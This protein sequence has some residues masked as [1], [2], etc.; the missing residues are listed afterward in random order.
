MRLPIKPERAP[1]VTRRGLLIGGGVGL[2]LLVGWSVWPREY[3]PNLTTSDGEHVFGGYL[4]IAEDGH[5]TVVVP[6]IEMGQGSYTL[7]PQILADE[8]GAD[9]RTIAVEPAPLNPIYANAQLARQWSEGTATWLFGDAARWVA[10]RTAEDVVYQISD[11]AA[12]AEAAA[13][14]RVAGAA[15]RAM[16]AMAAADRWGVDWAACET[17]DGFV[18]HGDQ[19]LRFGELAA[20]AVTY[21]P[22][23]PLPLRISGEHR[24]VGLSMPRLDLPAKVDGLA[25][26]AADIRLPEMVYA[27]IRMGPLG[28]TRFKTADRKALDGRRDFIRLVTHRNWVAAVG[29]TWWA[30]NAELEAIRPRFV[31]HG[32]LPDSANADRALDDA[33]AAEGVTMVATGN[34]DEAFAGA[35]LATATYHV[36]LGAHA[37]IE[38]MTA[39]AAVRDGRLE[40]WVSTQAPGAA[41]RAVARAT[42]YAEDD[43]IIHPMLVGGS[44]GRKL[45]IEVAVQAAQIAIAVER[46]VQLVWSRSEDMQQDRFGPAAAAKMFAR[47]DAAGR[48]AAWRARIAAPAAMAQ[49]RARLIDRA[50]PAEAEQASEGQTEPSMVSGAFPP[51]AIPNVSIDLHSAAIGVPTGRW[52]GGSDAASAFFSECFV[53]ELAAKA[54]MDPFLYRMGML[55]GMPRLAACLA[56]AIVIGEWEGG[57][58]GTDQG[59][60]CHSMNGTHVAVLADAFINEMQKIVVRRLTAVVDMGRIRHPVIARQQIE[61]GLIYGMAMALG[62]SVRIEKGIPNI[63]TLGKLALPVLSDCPDIAIEF[64]RSRADPGEIGEAGVPAVAPAIANALFAGSGRR[65]RSL[66][67]MAG[68]RP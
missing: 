10:S 16:L 35:K 49:T 27:A 60:A 38:P 12:T 18:T 43:V 66:P 7:I 40:L 24:L 55:S 51:Y 20:E 37:A 46:P 36:G 47:T 44:F 14:A 52:R 25:N 57:A 63:R 61:G 31:T 28:D 58:Q 30:A 41:R 5:V 65:F 2:G 32:V 56:R 6:E 9:W 26:F 54:G 34:V 23:D 19:K 29:R 17:F 50:S 33:L 3:F 22:P 15:G 4:K 64:V 21:D 67:L 39:T 11:G 48:I 8:L 53:D 45:E 1:L 42:G 59:I 68:E 62:A 13:A